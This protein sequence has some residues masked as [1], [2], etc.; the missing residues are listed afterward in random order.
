MLKRWLNFSSDI[1]VQYIRKPFRGLGYGSLSD[2]CWIMRSSAKFIPIRLLQALL[3]LCGG[4]INR[5]IIL[6][7][8]KHKHFWSYFHILK[9]L[10][11]AFQI[12]KICLK[13]KFQ[14]ENW[15]KFHTMLLSQ[16]PWQ[17]IIPVLLFGQFGCLCVLSPG[18]VLPIPVSV[19]RKWPDW[20]TFQS[21][22]PPLPTH[23]AIMFTVA[24]QK[25]LSGRGKKLLSKMT[26]KFWT[27]E[28]EFSGARPRSRYIPA[29]PSQSQPVLL[30]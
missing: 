22:S 16:C 6:N 8:R 25:G 18:S 28:F 23:M 26:R 1:R 9:V 24:L 29:L 3:S 11:N 17:Y 20:L 19:A 12:G 13:T 30:Y 27:N 10:L 7:Y 5:Q 14:V 15:R 2:I 4:Y 21:V